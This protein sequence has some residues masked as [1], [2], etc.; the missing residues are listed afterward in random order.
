VSEGVVTLVRRADADDLARRD[1]NRAVA[2]LFAR[3]ARP[4]LGMLTAY[5]GDAALAEELVQEA[6]VRL[7]RSWHRVRDADAASAYLRSIAFNLARS[8]FRRLQVARR[9]TPGREQEILGHS[10]EDGVVLREDRREV[11]AA[12]RTLPARQ[13]ECVLL[14]FWAGL[15]DSEIA[16][17]IG[18]SP[19]SVKTHLRR[20]LASLESKLGGAR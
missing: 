1:A 13:R 19:N 11:A 2:D 12:L 8:Q 3:D 20:G 16:T 7:H 10:A 9:R 14:R 5:T 15:S 18:I 4:L 6:F 17:S